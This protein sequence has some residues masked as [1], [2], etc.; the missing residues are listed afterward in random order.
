MYCVS[1]LCI[2]FIVFCSC[3]F[4]MVSRR[5][6]KTIKASTRTHLRSCWRLDRQGLHLQIWILHQTDP[7]GHVARVWINT[8][9]P[10]PNKTQA[11]SFCK[12]LRDLIFSNRFEKI[13]CA[14]VASWQGSWNS[15]H[16]S[17]A[18]PQHVLDWIQVLEISR[19]SPGSWIL[20]PILM[21]YKTQLTSGPVLSK[22]WLKSLALS[23]KFGVEWQIW[24]WVKKFGVEWSGL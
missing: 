18:S 8:R 7:V 17:W 21:V 1:V 3:V 10:K 16:Q 20:I 2:V 15:L 5:A 9:L 14:Q 12:T 6:K 24:R 4:C 22:K 23:K 13:R 19:L 11:A